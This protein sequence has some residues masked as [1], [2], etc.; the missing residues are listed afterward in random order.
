[1]DKRNEWPFHEG[2]YYAHEVCML[3]NG[4]NKNSTETIKREL[5]QRIN[6]LKFSIRIR[7]QKHQKSKH[8]GRSR[9]KTKATWVFR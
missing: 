8:N 2:S 7:T 9:P 1:M 5:V 3:H 6:S 4:M